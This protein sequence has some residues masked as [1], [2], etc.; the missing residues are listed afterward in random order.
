[1]SEL[2]DNETTTS[3]SFDDLFSDDE[4]FSNPNDEVSNMDASCEAMIQFGRNRAIVP[5]SEGLSLAEAT[6]AVA[7]QIGLPIKD[8]S[9]LMF[10]G[11]DRSRYL[12]PDATTVEPGV[13]YIVSDKVD[14]KGQSQDQ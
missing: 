14:D 8:L 4:F 5:V 13:V 10:Q 12:P 11:Q 2:F 7:D 6:L 1:M 9:K 3:N